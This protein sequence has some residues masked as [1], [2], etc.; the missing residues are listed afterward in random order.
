[1]SDCLIYDFE[2]HSLYYENFQKFEHVFYLELDTLEIKCLTD[3]GEITGIQGFLP[4]VNSV[5]E[6]IEIKSYRKG[7]VCIGNVQ[8]YKYK[9]NMTYDLFEE[10]PMLRLYLKNKLIKYDDNQGIIC[11]GSKLRMEDEI[12]KINKNRLCGID[13]LYNL[14]CMYIIPDKFLN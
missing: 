11:I 7:S 12:I 3:S 1:M 9:E 13:R 4:L 6:K 2:T 5:R 10:E 8:K 14:K